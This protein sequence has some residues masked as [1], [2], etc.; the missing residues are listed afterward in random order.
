MAMAI[1]TI[2]LRSNVLD[3]AA[4]RSKCAIEAK[5]HG[6]KG[7]R[8]CN[9]ERLGSTVCSFDWAEAGIFQW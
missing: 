6:Y 7:V 4:I 2:A 1:T 3:L 5:I 9:F 8:S